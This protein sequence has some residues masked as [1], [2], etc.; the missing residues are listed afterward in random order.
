MTRDQVTKRDN[1]FV[2]ELREN[3][4]GRENSI[5]S[6]QASKFLGEHGFPIKKSHIGTMINNLAGERCLSICY[7]NGK[8]YFW[9]TSK[10]EIQDTVAD[11]Q[12]RINA[13]QEH[14][15]HLNSFIIE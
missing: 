2:K 3:H 13:L 6:E 15:D 1:L 14:I 5:T 4:R 11:L 10:C 12:S 7:T 9:A 8:G